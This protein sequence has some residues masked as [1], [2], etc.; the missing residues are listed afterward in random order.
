MI[1][2]DIIKLV[3]KMAPPY[4]IDSWDNCGLE[5]GTEHK[6]VRRLLL[7][8]DITNEVVKYAIENEIDMVISHHPVFFNN[9][10]KLTRDD[11]RGKMIYDIIKGDITVFSVHSNLD[12]CI[13]GV[14]DILADTIGLSNTEVLSKSYTEKLYK[15]VV[16]VP[17]E[18]GDKVRNA[19]S[20]AGAGWIGNYSHCTFNLDGIG[21]FM[22]R[23][24]TNPFIGTYKNLERVKEV[25]IETIV[26]QNILKEAINQML[27][28]HPYEEVAYDI[29]PLY[30]KGVEY[31]YGRVGQLKQGIPLGNLGKLVKNKLNSTSVKIIGDINKEVRRVAVCGGS[32]GD[33]IKDAYNREADVFIT[34][35]IKYHQAQLAKELD[36]AIIDANHFNTEWII[37][38]TLGKYLQHNLKEDVEIIISEHNSAPFL[39]V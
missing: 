22:P 35:D 3:N 19:I 34:S 8:L 21:T 29:Y 31:G 17:T 23:E 14:S 15:L 33:F 38:P 16:F 4:L 7:A 1:A 24:G 28:A 2:R 11:E 13:G 39:V 25:R 26:R 12:V 27:Q 9:I 18:Y 5:L 20:E 10:K 6:E 37:L 36:L 32:G 30:N